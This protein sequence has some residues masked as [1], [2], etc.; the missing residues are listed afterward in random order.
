MKTIEFRIWD[1][2]EKEMIYHDLDQ[3]DTSIFLC[4]GGSVYS[5]DMECRDYRYEVMQY[6]GLKDTNG[7][8]IYDGDIIREYSKSQCL[9]EDNI[10]YAQGEIEESEDYYEVRWGDY[11][12]GE[13]VRQLECWLYGGNSLSDHIKGKFYYDNP[14]WERLEYRFE[15]VG[16]VYE[17]HNLL[18]QKQ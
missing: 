4:L 10:N 12:D 3:C 9:I 13:Y 7:V 11:C 1:K 18:N 8:E 5:D 15:V 14:Y 17:N 6:T 16:N 2:I